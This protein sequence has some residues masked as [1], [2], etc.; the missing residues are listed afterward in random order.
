MT[1]A[2]RWTLLAAIVASGIVF[3]DSTIVNL[4]LKRMGEELPRLTS[5]GVLEGQAYVGSGYLAVLAA[6][7]II[8]GA[9][10][11]RMG[12]RRIFIIGLS[13]FGFV[14]VL[15]GIAPSLE[16]MIAARLLQ[17]AAGSL[18]VPGSLAII[19]AAFDG[20]ARARAFGLWAAS[21]SAL[22]LL[23]PIVG[24]LLVDNLTWRLAFLINVPLVAIALWAAF[25][26]VQESRDEHAAGHFDWLGSVVGA[27]AV[28]GLA[29]GAIHGQ[30]TAWADPVAWLS[31]GVGAV[32]LVLFP[33]LMAVRPHPLVPLSLF[34]NREFASINL[35]TFLIYGALYVSF[36]YTALLYQ[37][38]LGYSATGAAVI[39]VPAGVLL[40]LLS[41]RFGTL[42]GRYGARR[43]LVTGPLIVALGF[44]WLA[45]IPAHSAP[46]HADLANPAT[47]IPPLDALIDVL[48]ASIASGL[49]M[50]MVVA[51]LTS[52][53]MNSIPSGN[54]GLGSAINN[55][56][57]RVG[58]P[59]LGAVIFIAITASF[60]TG[61]AN[62]VP[63]LDTTSAVVQAAVQ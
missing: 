40:A 18:L 53:L 31:L 59:L 4:A 46:W 45:R 6:L 52:T 49:G 48:P 29:F 33:I 9:L 50:A 55:A 10:A 37:G 3:L 11:D 54:S 27:L 16:F 20:P 62:R 56:L 41:A 44:L 36:S 5:I 63:G 22:T 15:C 17:G 7:L 43:F 58:Q 25:R 57:S 2:Q 28:G 21:T 30:E 13:T 60:Y 12:R 19:T 35:A 23:G 38:T 1:R 26:H 42:T 34:R 24:G 47:W 32:C 51:P 61:L 8:S 14:S 39:G